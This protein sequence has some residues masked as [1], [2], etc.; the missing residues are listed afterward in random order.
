MTANGAANDT[1]ADMEKVLAGGKSITSLNHFMS[2]Y[3]DKIS[4]DHLH[5]ANSLW[6]G[7]GRV[8]VYKDFLQ[9]N[10]SYYDAGTFYADFNDKETVNAINSWISE[11]T[12]GM[13]ND[14]LKE[15]REDNIMFLVN[16]ITF[17]AE[18]KEYAVLGVHENQD[19]KNYN[20]TVSKFT[21]FIYKGESKRLTLGKGSGVIMPYKDCNFS[22]VALLPDEGTN[23]Y[24]YLAS[25]EGTGFINAVKSAERGNGN[26]IY[27]PEF[28]IKSS[29]DLNAP[30]TELGMGSAFSNADF[31]KLGVARRPISISSVNQDAVISVTRVGTK[32]SAATI[33]G[34]SATSVHKQ[35]KFN[36][37][38]VYAIID[39]ATCLP[40]FIGVNAN[41]D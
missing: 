32:A 5:I 25:I 40:V 6:I 37:P 34:I 33:D 41:M 11:H 31:T 20:G 19:F 1:L 26:D 3:A 4:G 23:V 27:M 38:F 13:I 24:D 29:L 10:A 22:F 28:E 15:I 14:M 18:W 21:E 39:N 2:A 9:T 30:L 7:N 36:R 16:A 12:D 35:F 17:E 8:N